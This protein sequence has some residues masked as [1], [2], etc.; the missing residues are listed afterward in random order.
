MNEMNK[1][2]ETLARVPNLKKKFDHYNF[3]L[4]VYLGSARTLKATK[5]YFLTALLQELNDS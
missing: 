4:F 1:N 2:E 3:A 5:M